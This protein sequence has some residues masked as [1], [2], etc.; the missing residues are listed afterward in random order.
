VLAKV[1]GYHRILG[2]GDAEELRTGVM[3]AFALLEAG[4]QCS[5]PTCVMMVGSGYD[6]TAEGRPWD[7]VLGSAWGYHAQAI[8]AYRQSDDSVGLLSSWGGE[9]VFWVPVTTLAKVASEF[10]CIDSITRDP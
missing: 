4:G 2:E 8:G 7:G 6:A 3:Q 9:R 10:W 5:Y 1:S